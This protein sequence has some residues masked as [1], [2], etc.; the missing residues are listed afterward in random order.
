MP[1]AFLLKTGWGTETPFVA[2][3]TLV[4][5]KVSELWFLQLQMKVNIPPNAARLL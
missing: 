5:H 4:S 1:F 3:V 2:C